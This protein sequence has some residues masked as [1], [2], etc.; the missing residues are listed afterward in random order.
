[1][2]PQTVRSQFY[3]KSGCNEIRL[4]PFA[5]EYSL[6]ASYPF[7][8]SSTVDLR[9]WRLW[10]RMQNNSQWFRLIAIKFLISNNLSGTS[11]G[12]TTRAPSPDKTSSQKLKSKFYNVIIRPSFHIWLRSIQSKM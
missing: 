9:R 6:L 12:L 2:A 1:L 11:N 4:H 7:S 3:L 8:L 10:W 5:I